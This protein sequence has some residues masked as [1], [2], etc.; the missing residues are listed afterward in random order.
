MYT[1]Y[2]Y[3]ENGWKIL[4]YPLLADDGRIVINPILDE[5]LNTHGSLKFSIAQTNP[6]YSL[7]EP[8]NTKI[9]VVS[10]TKGRKPWFGRVM[11]IDKGWNNCLS[12]YC[13]G[14]LSCLLDTNRQPYGFSGDI[15]ETDPSDPAYPGLLPI[16]INSYNG[17]NTNGY[18]FALGNV[19][20]TDP[21]GYIVRS[22]STPKEIW[23]IMKDALFN[24][25]LGGYIMPRYDEENDIHYIDYLSLDDNDPYAH[26]SSQTIKF[27]EN[28]LNFKNYVNAS[29]IV[30][31]LVP[32]G[33]QFDEND[34]HYEAGPPTNGVWNGNRLRM[35]TDR[36]GTPAY[37]ENQ[38]GIDMWGRIVGY[39]I[40]DDVTIATNLENKARAWLEQQIWESVTLEVSAV[41]LSFVDVD[42]EQIQVGDYVRVQSKPHAINVL[43]LCT[44]K[45]TYLTELEKSAIV[46]GAGQKTI[47]DLQSQSLQKEDLN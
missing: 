35:N 36:P 9:K 12:V 26:T 47:T 17:S 37:V 19:S 43:L 25:S 11:Q 23:T 29:N 8:R 5:K 6:F 16:L 14:E 28:L 27:G 18:V 31:V 32:Y 40:W 21:N 39:R 1:I 45:T 30:T 44:S 15:V 13:E 7:I 46:L 22:S 10:D 24:S 4:H 2:A 38:T 42:I 3:V 34:S 41:D 20:V 33:A